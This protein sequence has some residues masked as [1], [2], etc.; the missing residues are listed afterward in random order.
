GAIIRLCAN[1]G[2]TL[3]LVEPLGFSLED[4]LLRR[5]GLDYHDL[6][7]VQIHASWEALLEHVD[8][9]MLMFTSH[10]QVRYDSVAYESTDWLIFGTEPTGLSAELL[11]YTSQESH[12]VIPMRP[13]NRSLNLS[14]AAT[15]VLYEGWRQLGFYGADE[16]FDPAP[17][18][19]Q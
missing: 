19:E 10:G 1:T 4:R 18:A 11:T 5:A 12:I 3:H 14:N 7:D 17:V 6:A 9:R 8:G 13:N 15:L 2:A 16:R